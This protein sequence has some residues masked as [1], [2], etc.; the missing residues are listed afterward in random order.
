MFSLRGDNRNIA[1][2]KSILLVFSDVNAS[3]Q[4]LSIVKNLKSEDCM[5][6][7]VLIGSNTP[8]IAQDMLD[9]GISLKLLS[10]RGKYLSIVL[11]WSVW[12]EVVKYAVWESAKLHTPQR[13]P[14]P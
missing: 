12:L 5:L 3:P 6:R 13:A 1:K 11:F 4:L 8:K 10:H 7:V 14:F 2:K 9:L